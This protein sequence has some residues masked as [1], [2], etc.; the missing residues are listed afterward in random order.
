M[1]VLTGESC[2]DCTHWLVLSRLYSLVI[3]VSTVLA[4]SSKRQVLVSLEDFRSVLDD[5]VPSVNDEDL[6]YFRQLHRQL[7][8]NHNQLYTH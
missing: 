8:D 4:G 6:E 2:L 5:L 7:G 1:T 3:L